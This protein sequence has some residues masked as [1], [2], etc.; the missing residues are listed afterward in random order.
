MRQVAPAAQQLTWI[1]P[2]LSQ[3]VI[4]LFARIPTYVLK[5]GGIERDGGAKGVRGGPA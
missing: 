2:L 4:E 5:A 1:A 3:P